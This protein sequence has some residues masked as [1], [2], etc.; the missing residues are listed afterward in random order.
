[1][2]I[3]IRFA[4][5]KLVE[6]EEIAFVQTATSFRNGLPYAIRPD[7][8][9][10]MIPQEETGAGTHIDVGKGVQSPFIEDKQSGAHY[11]KGGKKGRSELTRIAEM[12]DN[13]GIWLWDG[14]SGEMRFETAAMAVKGAQA[15]AYYGAASWGW[16]RDPHGATKKLPFNR[17][18]DIPNAGEVFLKA[19][20]LW[21]ESKTADAKPTIHLPTAE[22]K[23]ITEKTKLVDDPGKPGKT[24]AVELDLNTRLE[25]TEIK[26]PAHADWRNVVVVSG[27]HAGARGWVKVSLSDREVFVPKKRR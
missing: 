8:E 10:R 22:T 17:A 20:K 6:S 27:P 19:A 7:V 4:P 16:T 3:S 14:D 18:G 5:N 24:P 1:V 26:D 12:W 9:S 2:E 23:Y 21:D 11:I 13:P 15:G 25:V